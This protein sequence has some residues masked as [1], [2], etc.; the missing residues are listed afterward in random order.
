MNLRV[1]TPPAS[2]PVSIETV[3]SHLRVDISDDDALIASYLTTAREK[4]EGIARRAFVT[5][6]LELVIDDWPGNGVLKLPRPPLQSVSSVR[7]LDDA[8]DE[9]TFTDYLVDARS[10]PGKIIFKSFPS[11]KLFPSGAIAIRFVAGYGAAGSV[12]NVF[13]QGILMLVGHWYENREAVTANNF[14]AYEIPIG[15]K[16]LFLSDRARWF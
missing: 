4:G 8:G 1:I 13:V 15:P 16:N 11:Q 6:T 9:H 2:E 10:E 12:P 7:Y 3:K 5:Q 14:Q